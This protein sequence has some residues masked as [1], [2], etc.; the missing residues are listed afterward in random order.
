MSGPEGNLGTAAAR[1]EAVTQLARAAS[2]AMTPLER[3]EGLQIV[4]SRLGTR[5]PRRTALMALSLLGTMAAATGAVVLV[6]SAKHAGTSAIDTIGYRVEGGEIGDGGYI[7]SFEPAGAVLRFDEGTELR[8]MT[9]ARGRLTSI[10]RLGARLAI[11]EGEAQVKV[12]PRPGARWLVDAGPFLITVRGT[13][14]TASWDGATEQL[15]INMEKGLV[16]VTGPLADGMLAVRAGQH[17]TVNM[18]KKE[19]LLR[20]IDGSGA[21]SGADAPAASWSARAQGGD[22]GVIPGGCRGPVEHGLRA[23]RRAT[24][25]SVLFRRF[26]VAGRLRWPPE[27]SIRSFGMP[28]GAA[29]GARSRTRPATIWRRSRMPPVTGGGTTSRCGL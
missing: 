23:R 14:F 19:V 13:V 18:Q 6:R 4:T 24:R 26:R 9:G 17:L 3:M 15:D 5:R 8:L 7:R 16:S 28:S 27:I 2:R 20:Q 11:E 29:C 21:R 10:D 22:Q 12:T 1:L 25:L